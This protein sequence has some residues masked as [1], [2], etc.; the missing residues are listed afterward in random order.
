[1]DQ[2]H[3][4]VLPPSHGGLV[5][6]SWPDIRQDK[7]G[8]RRQRAGRLVSKPNFFFFSLTTHSLSRASLPRLAWVKKKVSF[9]WRMRSMKRRR[10]TGGFPPILR[11][12]DEVVRSLVSISNFHPFLVTAPL[13]KYPG[14]IIHICTAHFF[15]H[16][17]GLF[18]S[19]S[20]LLRKSLCS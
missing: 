3:R 16:S 19:L 7:T 11:P 9:W 20:T 1:M 2:G 18:L 4:V 13:P 5:S 6:D 10:R 14:R 17:H 15:T 12:F 8:V